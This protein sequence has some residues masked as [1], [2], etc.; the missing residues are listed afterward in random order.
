MAKRTRHGRDVVAFILQNIEDHPRDIARFTSQNFKVTRQ[1]INRFLRELVSEGLII[2]VG[3]TSQRFY[4]LNILRK[5][6]FSLS[7]QGLQEDNVWRVH[8]APLLDDLP[9]NVR[10]IWE[11]SISEMVNNAVDHSGGTELLVHFERNASRTQIV[12]HDNG[13]GI[14]R[15]IKEECHLED[16]RHAVLELAKGKLTTDPDKHT[17][18]GIFFT[19]RMLDDFAI[20]SGDVYFTHKFGEEEDW[21]TQREK[22]DTGTSVFMFLTNDS[23]RTNQEVFDHFASEENDYGFNKTVVPVRLAKHG[24][25]QLVSRSQAKRLLAR[26]DRFNIV[27]FDFATVETIGPAFADEI[28]RVFERS[29]P[30]I[31]LIPVNTVPG[32]D[33]MI[34]RAR[35]VSDAS[36]PG[37]SEG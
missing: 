12:L 2:P 1:A 33:Q 14:F 37:P 18:E 26:I 6:T 36:Q 34:S 15:K 21:I 5:E 32:I 20:L 31:R 16:E 11:Y 9:P 25:E 24:L 17:G 13:I 10:S 30:N 7:L 29:H 19:S 28:F 8:L 35:A 23:P 22:P 27:I 4:K 3:R